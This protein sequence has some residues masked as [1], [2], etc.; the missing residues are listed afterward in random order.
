MTINQAQLKKVALEAKSKTSDKRWLNA[1]DAA[2]AGVIS[3]W[4]IISELFDSVLITTET[5]KSYHANG[6][7]QC[8]AFK[9][10][11]ACKH[12]A[13][14]RLIQLYNERAN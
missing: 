5:G 12:R 1:I 10:G 4:W 14:F 6:R 3:G 11:T 8:E 13:L 9:R 7:C 2:L